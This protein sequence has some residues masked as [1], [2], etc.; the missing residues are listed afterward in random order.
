MSELVPNEVVERRILVLRGQKVMLD[1]D[2][3]ELYEVEV[4]TLNQ[5]VKRNASRFP[6]DFMFQ[7]SDEEFAILRSQIVISR[8][9]GGRRFPPYAFTEHGVTM[10]SSVLRSERAAQVNI[11]VVRAFI[12]LREVLASNADLARR[13]D[14]MEATYDKQFEAVFDAIRMLMLEPDKPTKPIGF[15][16]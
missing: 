11:A 4:R 7:L 13:M 1:E 14:A 16:P 8:S 12:R 5:A 2:L 10:L 9:W 15:K 6:A 3:A